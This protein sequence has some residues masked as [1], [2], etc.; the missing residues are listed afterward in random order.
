MGPTTVAKACRASVGSGKT[1]LVSYSWSPGHPG[2]Q[3]CTLQALRVAS[4]VPP[5]RAP[6]VQ[7]PQCVPPARPGT[8]LSGLHAGGV[9]I[10][11]VSRPLPH[12]GAS[13][14]LLPPSRQSRPLAPFR[15]GRAPSAPSWRSAGR[16][17]SSKT[18]L[19]P[20]GAT[21]P[22]RRCGGGTSAY[23][24]ASADLRAT[25]CAAA[26]FALAVAIAVRLG[27]GAVEA[28]FRPAAVLRVLLRRALCAPVGGGAGARQ[29][30][31]SPQ[32]PALWLASGGGADDAAWAAWAAR[33]LV[34]DFGVPDADAAA[35]DAALVA[36]NV[37]RLWRGLLSSTTAVARS[38]ARGGEPAGG[39]GATA[40]GGGGTGGGGGGGGGGAALSPPSPTPPTAGAV[41]AGAGRQDGYD[42]RRRSCTV[43]CT[44]SDTLPDASI[45]HLPPVPVLA[46]QH[47]YI[48]AHHHTVSRFRCS[49]NK[50]CLPT[51]YLPSP[52]LVSDSPNVSS[53][54]HCCF[55]PITAAFPVSVLPP[56]CLCCVPPR[57]LPPPTAAASPLRCFLPSR[58][59][60]HFRDS[61]SAGVLGGRWY[62]AFL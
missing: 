8:P 16:A 40:I 17:A 62:S 31:P 60:E 36:A 52:S 27:P 12:L 57:L 2:S 49:S 50:Q 9:P 28:G 11:R 21:S 43:L 22:L 18:T 42:C 35:A 15:A 1:I 59:Q 14:A 44:V 24:D 7:A 19:A 45:S 20:V 26:A 4:S 30:P 38:A 23:G 46:P 41:A 55:P 25:V 51:L 37:P 13:T 34:S 5:M 56:P 47:R 39:P 10:S 33:L 61:S 3:L 32:P 53:P 54:D 48:L 6:S 29:P 58:V